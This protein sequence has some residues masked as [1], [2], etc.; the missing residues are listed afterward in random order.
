MDKELLENMQHEFDKL[1]MEN[2]HNLRLLAIRIDKLEDKF[3]SDIEAC[4]KYAEEIK[5]I[6]YASSVKV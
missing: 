6:M 3:K 2:E 5:N 4:N 1:R